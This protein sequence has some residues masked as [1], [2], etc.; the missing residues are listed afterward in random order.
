[1]CGAN[2]S[3]YTPRSVH[4]SPRRRWNRIGQ[5]YR[6]EETI[7][8]LPPDRRRRV[9]QR[10]SKPIIGALAGWA[11]ETVR[12]LSRKSE[13]AAAFRYMRARWAALVRCFDDVT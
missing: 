8:G 3:T 6:I 9:R 1:M 4:R 7:K 13:L 2:S 12:K 10:R 11:D 5:L